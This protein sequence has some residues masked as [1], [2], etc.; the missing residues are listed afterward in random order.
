V[1]TQSISN[2]KR[3]EV[4]HQYHNPV[5]VEPESAKDAG[6][7]IAAADFLPI[8]PRP[9]RPRKPNKDFFK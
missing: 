8:S 7:K 6:R 5:A 1:L 3:A 9:N 2:E 4:L